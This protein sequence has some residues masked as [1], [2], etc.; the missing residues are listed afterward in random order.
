[1]K[2]KLEKFLRLFGQ[3]KHGMYRVDSGRYTILW[4]GAIINEGIDELSVGPTEKLCMSCRGEGEIPGSWVYYPCTPCK[5]TGFVD[6]EKQ[7]NEDCP[8][9]VDEM[10][11]DLID[12][13]E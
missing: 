8:I 1:M 2:A 7:P 4:R 10:T 9:F 13:D 6:D 12:Y 3:H 5:G 11:I